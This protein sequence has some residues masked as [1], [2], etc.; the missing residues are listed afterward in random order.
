MAGIGVRSGM[1]GEALNR[2]PRRDALTLYYDSDPLPAGIP[3]LR[4]LFV[5]RK[6]KAD[7]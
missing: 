7:P 6:S 2:Q 5:H 1:P 3:V 4:K